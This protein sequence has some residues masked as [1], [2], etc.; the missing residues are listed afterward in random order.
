MSVYKAINKVQDDLSKEGI[1]KSRR[2]TQGAGYNFRGIDE[3]FNAISP[4][5]AKHGLC[6]LPRVLSRECVERQSKAGGA[7]FYV[8]L[9]VE[10][11]FVATEDGSKH[12][13]KT[14][15]EAMDSGDKATNKAMSA[16]YKYACLQTFA[17]PTEGDNDPDSH[18]YEVKAMPSA[19]PV[20]KPIVKPKVEEKPALVIDE[21][22]PILEFA[23]G[24]FASSQT[25]SEL[26]QWFSQL[27]THTKKLP[28]EQVVITN[29]YNSR[30][31]ELEKK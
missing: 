16:A 8:T 28:E 26:K 30:K 1:S 22:M 4:L 15:G 13:V 14:F 2:N 11:D 18:S 23:E 19:K 24:A 6:I 7:L 31:A 21:G 25:M 27:Y 12:T 5:L 17:I 10:F 3:V 20:D 29:L 9:D